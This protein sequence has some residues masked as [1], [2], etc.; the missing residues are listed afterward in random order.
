MGS[1]AGDDDTMTREFWPRPG[2]RLAFV[3]AILSVACM[4]ALILLLLGSMAW[5]SYKARVQSQ[6]QTEHCRP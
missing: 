2:E 6:Q 4:I 3:A 1:D 5:D